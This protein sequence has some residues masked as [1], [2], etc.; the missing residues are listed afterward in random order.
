MKAFKINNFTQQIPHS[1]LQTKFGGQPDWLTTPIWPVSPVWDNRPMKFMGQIRLDHIYD[2]IKKTKMAYIFI[3]QPNDKEDDFFD[4][5]IIFPDGGENAVIIQP[6]GNIPDFIKTEEHKTGPTVDREYIWIPHISTM[7]EAAEFEF[8]KIDIDKFSGTPAFFQN[9]EVGKNDRLLLQLHTN[10][11]P[12][13]INAGG[14][15]TLF[16]MVNEHIHEG[17]ILIEDM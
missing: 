9:N 2:D 16:V 15:S 11:L 7:E 8:E 3:T 5:D 14:A 12:F 1:S 10:W 13:Y 6:D 4:P 17:Y